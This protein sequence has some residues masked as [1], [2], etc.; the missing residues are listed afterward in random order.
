M[1]KSLTLIEL[2]VVIAII[3]ILAAMLLPALSAARERA[4]SASCIANLKQVGTA[5][6]MYAGD[7]ASFVP[8]YT[9][10]SSGHA[11]CVLSMTKNWGSRQSLGYLLVIGDYFPE[12]G[13]T[14]TN[15]GG[16]GSYFQKIKERYFICPSDTNNHTQDPWMTSYTNFFINSAACSA[17][18]GDAYGGTESA[19]CIIGSDRVD[20]AII[21]DTFR[22]NNS[23]NTEFDNHPGNINTLKL[24]G[25]VTAVNAGTELRK[26]A[27]LSNAIGIYLD[28]I[29]K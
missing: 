6:I 19:R 29:K 28:E 20:N 9:K 3:A 25:H 7:N 13:L 22:R 4:R 8:C 17:H 1:K 12:S 27:T 2:L 24:G 18:T 5:I 11:T 21:F 16:D 14:Y 26:Q 23:A 10:C 15:F